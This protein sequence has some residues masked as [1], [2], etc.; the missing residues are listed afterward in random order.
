MNPRAKPLL[1]AAAAASLLW[2]GGCGTTPESRIA[3][4]PDVFARLT[5]DEQTMV[6]NGKVGIGME[7]EVVKLALGDPDRVTFETTAQGQTE[8]WHYETTVYYDGAFLY[9]GPYWHR[10][11]PY[12]GGYWGAGPWAFDAPAAVYDRFRIALAN[13]RVTSIRQESP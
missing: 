2:V 6:R 8:I 1:L 5:P 4:H 13:G 11:H 3:E 10:R 12:W 9:P 7:A